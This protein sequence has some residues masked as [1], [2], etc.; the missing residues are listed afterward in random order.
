MNLEHISE[1]KMCSECTR[2]ALMRADFYLGGIPP[3]PPSLGMLKRALIGPL[4]GPSNINS[5]DAPLSQIQP[6]ILC[7][8]G[9][10]YYM[11]YPAAVEAFS[12]S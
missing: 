1:S 4:W 5:L 3:D 11:Q 9:V 7:T 12:S 10:G 8:I 2:I 6:N